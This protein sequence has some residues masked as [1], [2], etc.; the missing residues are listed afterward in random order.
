MDLKR[1]AAMRELV[2][3]Q[4]LQRAE[5]ILTAVA[6]EAGLSDSKFTMVAQ[7]CF[8]R[9]MVGIQGYGIA[10]YSDAQPDRLEHELICEHLDV[11]NWSMFI[12]TRK[13]VMTK[14]R[15][16]L[17]HKMILNSAR[18]IL[19]LDKLDSTEDKAQTNSPTYI[20][21]EDETEEEDEREDG[22][23]GDEYPEE[24]DL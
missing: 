14:K 20:E 12:L 1:R 21:D 24:R 2:R 22:L 13:D 5:K 19:E 10:S 4:E 8:F 16:A 7:A 17:L 18:L 9:R 23:G 11:I 3:G 6:K 15:T